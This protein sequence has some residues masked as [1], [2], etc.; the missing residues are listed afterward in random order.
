MQP[1]KPTPKMQWC[2]RLQER[3]NPA[4]NE[5]SI[6]WGVQTGKV[7]S[8]FA[9]RLYQD[10]LHNFFL[11]PSLGKCAYLGRKKNNGS[12]LNS[13]YHFVKNPRKKN[14]PLHKP[15][16]GWWIKEPKTIT[17]PE[18]LHTHASSSSQRNFVSSNQSKAVRLARSSPHPLA[19]HKQA[20]C[21]PLVS[22]FS[23]FVVVVVRAAILT[24]EEKAAK[25]RA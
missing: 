25:K 21:P 8:S 15:S 13:H 6:D 23:L 4:T 17:L 5:W 14:C 7:D 20:I 16:P 10:L 22:P 24:V 3:K 11:S 18:F 19:S 2:P 12:F 1:A 9:L